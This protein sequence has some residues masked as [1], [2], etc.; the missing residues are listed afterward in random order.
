MFVHKFFPTRSNLVRKLET[1]RKR[2]TSATAYNS[3]I[4]KSFP[5]QARIPIGKWPLAWKNTPTASVR[6]TASCEP[7]LAFAQVHNFKEEGIAGFPATP[8]TSKIDVGSYVNHAWKLMEERRLCWKFHNF[9]PK[10]VTFAHRF[11]STYCDLIRKSITL[12]KRTRSDTT[13]NSRITEFF[14]G[15]A[16]ISIGKRPSGE[17]KILRRPLFVGL[18]LSS[19]SSTARKSTNLRKKVP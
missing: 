10:D 15:Q 12:R 9:P 11:F 13:C 5:G 7:K 3:R 17:P 1:S 4:V 18:Y 6:G 16:G 19:P 2:V 14:S 8:R